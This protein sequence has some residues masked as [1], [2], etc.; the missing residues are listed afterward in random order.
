MR[1]D[2]D[3]SGYKGIEM[4]ALE[5][6]RPV[7]VG[8]HAPGVL[9]VHSDRVLAVYELIVVQEGRLPIAEEDAEFNVGQDEWLI[10]RAGRRHFGTGAISSNMWF[11]WSCFL[12]QESDPDVAEVVV[13]QTGVVPSG[14]RVRWLFDNYL[15]DERRDRGHF[16]ADAYLGLLLN[17]IRIDTR[18]LARLRRPRDERVVAQVKEYVRQQ[19]SNPALTTSGVGREL[20][21]NPDHLGRVFRAVVGKTIVEYIHYERISRAKAK[22]EEED[23]TVERVGL[24]VGLPNVRYFRRLFVRIVGVTPSQYRQMFM[25]RRPD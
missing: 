24:A 14:D 13:A 3:I 4:L 2:S 21:Y 9:Q 7:A 1:Y 5:Q 22:F 11:Y 20:G 19:I 16:S 23:L 8:T 6:V 12:A 25:R 18:H 15:L 17:E 10:L